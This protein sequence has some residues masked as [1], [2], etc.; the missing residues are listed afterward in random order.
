VVGVARDA[1]DTDELD[2]FLACQDHRKIKGRTI[3]PA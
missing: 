3:R 2:L 1:R